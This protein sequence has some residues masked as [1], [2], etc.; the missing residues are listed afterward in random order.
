LFQEKHCERWI[1]VGSALPAASNRGDVIGQPGGGQAVPMTLNAG[2]AIVVTAKPDKRTRKKSMSRRSG[3][4]GYIEKR[5]NAFYVRFRIDVP[6]QDQRAYACVRICPMSGPGKM[7]KPERERRAKEIITESGADTEAHFKS[8]AATNLGVSFRQQAEWFMHHVQTRNR[9]PVKPATVKSWDNCIK[10]WLKPHLGQ[11][12]IS[13][14]NNSALRELVAVMV[15]AKLSAKSI[16]NYVQLVK[17]VVASAVDEQGE[18]L[19]PRKWNHEFMD[20]PEVRNQRRPTFTADVVTSLVANAEGQHSVLF[21]LLA[22]SGIRIG[23]AAGLEVTDVSP[24]GLTL[25]IR[26]SVWNGQ[27]QRPKTT[28]AFRQVDLHPSLALLV[29]AHMAQRTSGL[30]FSTTT[31]KPISQTNILKRSL[32]PILKALGL[33]KAGFHAFRRYRVTHLRKNR[34]PEDLLRFWIGHADRS[35]TDSYSKVKE[36]VAFRQLCAANLGL[37]FELPSENP[38]EKPVVARNARKMMKAETLSVAA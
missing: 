3:Q 23:E 1:D 36:D 30:L 27:V 29:R 7:T 6:G 22:G 13:A 25:T 26:Q 20:L 21:A 35:V 8:V 38:A 14:V 37:G 16:H 11:M 15:S 31:G 4:K 10:V 19:H 2:N 33:E 34:V 9:K 17:M 12:P 5:G 28:N 32:Y 24:D 18:E